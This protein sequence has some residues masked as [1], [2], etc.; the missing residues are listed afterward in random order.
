MPTYRI[1]ETEL[2]AWY[3]RYLDSLGVLYCASA[4]GLR[5]SYPQA[6]KMKR[7]GYKKGFPDIFIA[8]P[9]K[10]YH[11]LFIEL[12]YKNKPTKEQKDWK[13]ALESKGYRS[14]IMP[15]NLEIKPAQNWLI[16]NTEFYLGIMT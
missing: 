6:V 2:Q 15:H 11:G 9:R 3:C 7:M 16:E 10:Q 5:T 1:N 4:G 8:E 14:L 13:I 12:K